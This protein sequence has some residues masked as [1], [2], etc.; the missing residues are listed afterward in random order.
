MLSHPNGWGVQQQATLRTTLAKA[1]P[2]ANLLPSEDTDRV[3]FVSEAEAAVHFALHYTASTS[4]DRWLS[5][6]FVFVPSSCERG[7]N[8][9]LHVAGIT[10]YGGRRWWVYR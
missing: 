6:S 9:R 1:V 2:S 8:S 7:L 4:I 3:V 5:V 10:V